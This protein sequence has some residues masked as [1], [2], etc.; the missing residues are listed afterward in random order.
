[1]DDFARWCEKHVVY[2]QAAQN[3][4][5]QGRVIVQFVVERDGSISHVKVLQGKHKKLNDEAVRV[6]KSAPKW[7]PGTNR[8]KPV[9]IYVNVP[10][11]FVLCD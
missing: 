3:R 10:I 2:P 1:M 4:G 7:T 11:D 6:I 5:L 9:R 8:G